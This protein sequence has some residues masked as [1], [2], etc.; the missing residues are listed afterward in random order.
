MEEAR[1]QAVK[2]AKAD[3]KERR[4]IAQKAKARAAAIEI[5]RREAEA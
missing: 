5:A 2:K 4:A 1:R 3:A